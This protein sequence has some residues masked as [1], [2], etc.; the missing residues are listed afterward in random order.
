MSTVIN[1]QVSVPPRF[2][3]AGRSAPIPV[4]DQLTVTTPTARPG[5]IVV[6]VCGEVDMFTAS[7]LRDRLHDQIRHCGPDL[8]VDLTDVGFLAVTGLSVLN[9]ARTAAIAAEIGFCLVA[10]TPQ[11]LR[12]L[13]I[14]ELHGVIACYPDLDH[15]PMRT[16]PLDVIGSP[17]LPA[18]VTSPVRRV[19]AQLPPHRPDLRPA[20]S[21]ARPDRNLRTGEQ[22]S[23]K[24]E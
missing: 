15:A 22:P 17:H 13:G 23:T 10:D 1:S 8:V 20:R 24:D 16:Q 18:P 7:L 14:T 6:T 21:V 19:L 2:A 11:V 3:T 12:L 9:T 4:A 5:T